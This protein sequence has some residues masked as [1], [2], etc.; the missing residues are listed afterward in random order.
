MFSADYLGSCTTRVPRQPRVVQ[1][2]RAAQRTRDATGRCIDGL[3]TVRTTAACEAICAHSGSTLGAAPEWPC[4]T[5]A[6]RR[7]PLSHVWKAL[8]G[9][10]NVRPRDWPAWAF[11]VPRRAA[12]T[13]DPTPPRPTV[14]LRLAQRGDCCSPVHLSVPEL[15]S[16]WQ[17][18][19][20]CCT[21]A[22]ITRFHREPAFSCNRC[23]VRTAGVVRFRR[24]AA[25]K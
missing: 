24:Y 9:S 16:L 3:P 11:A 12:H 21:A 25:E 7:K 2:V 13:I 20:R 1:E 19:A 15:G 14:P 22:A 17:C 4:A 10:C 8:G 6:R 5:H 18:V 23:S